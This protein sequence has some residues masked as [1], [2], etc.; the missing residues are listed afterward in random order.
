MFNRTL[1]LFLGALSIAWIGYIGINLISSAVAPYPSNVF[2]LADTSVIVIHHPEE[3]DLDNE[4]MQAIQDNPLFQQLL[5]KTE[6]VQH[7]YFS[8]NRKLVVLE[9]SKP[10]TIK[11]MEN[12]F[13][14]FGYSVRFDNAKSF[15]LSNGWVGK[16]TDNYLLLS[17]KEWDEKSDKSIDWKF[18]DRKSSAS[19]LQN[20]GVS[21][22]IE[23]SYYIDKNNVKY[24]SYTNTKALP[25]VND[26][27]VFQ[28][29][30]PANFTGYTFYETNLLQQLSPGKH[31]IFEWLRYGAAIIEMD[32][33][34]CIVTDF[35][36]GQDPIAILS[37]FVDESDGYAT[38]KNAQ[39][40]NCSMPKE[41]KIGK[42]WKIEIFNNIALIAEDNAA[43]DKIIGAYETG[44]TLAQASL[45]RDNVF[46]S[47]PKKVS[48][49]AI[50]SDEHVTKSYL[51]NSIHTVVE[52]YLSADEKQAENK[53]VVKQL[54]PLRLDAAVNA[55]IPI[56]GS[57]FVYATTNSNTVYYLNS[58]AIVWSNAISGQII[59]TP[60]ILPN[61]EQLVVTATDGISIFNKDGSLQNGAPIPLNN[62]VSNAVLITWK[63]QYHLAVVA[64]NTITVFATNGKKIAS[65]TCSVAA[66][67]DVSLAVQGKKGE[68]IGHVIQNGVWSTYNLN[69]KRVIK[70][71]QVGE[72]KW[73]FVKSANT[74]AAVGMSQRKFIR[75]TENGRSSMLVGNI[76]NV[77]RQQE[78]DDEALFFVYQQQRIYVISNTG[79]I[80]TQFDTRVRR[81][82]DAYLA[83][84]T[85]GK[86]LVSIV[87][88][89][90]NNSYLYSLSGN[91]LGKQQFEGSKKIALHEQSDGQLVLISQANNYLVRYV[92]Y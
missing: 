45:R 81:I 22:S 47:T 55:L 10:W 78:K 59:G 14:Q 79:E 7:F 73:F 43:I 21:F 88:G 50:S 37:S 12:Y 51:T 60:F 19:I 2:T 24:I 85:S 35:K 82:E 66:G 42:N 92:V 13:D 86:T 56:Q 84:L 63:G 3:I 65:T 23:N 53:D 48:Y 16:Y 5:S 89:I 80:V 44:N 38:E 72:G 1:L 31:P 18:V 54:N 71:Q 52:N 41:L 90:S 20:K 64:G 91:D 27:E 68:L 69:R 15:K 49:R 28:E 77:I 61:T 17:E 39:I 58:S 25:L 76:S 34:Q 6:R 62:A 4:Q 87:D 33:E 30:I 29:F 26:Q 32:G 9:R 75:I 74:I 40:N 83:K 57:Q 67:Q 11:N 8:G 70:N 46:S 36:N